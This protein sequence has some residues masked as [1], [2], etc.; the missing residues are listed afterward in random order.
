MAR[1][2]PIPIDEHLLR[3]WP[4]PAA[5][6]DKSERGTVLVVGGSRQTPGAVLLAAEAALRVGAGKVQIATAADTAPALAV[7]LPEAFVE[8]LPVLRGG[9]L[10]VAGSDRILELAEDVDVVLL[11][12]GLS[13]P[14]CASL[15]LAQVVPRLETA[16][17]ID[18]L[19]TAYLTDHLDG[20]RHLDGRVLLTPNVAELAATLHQKED[21]VDNDPLGATR[22]LASA[23]GAV[24]LGGAD[25]SYVA[26]PQDDVWWQGSGSLGLAT[27]GSG[28]VKA[29]AVVGLV[30][31]GATPQQAAA[32]GS[33]AHGQAGER[34]AADEPGFLA[35]DLL[36]AIPLELSRLEDADG[37]AR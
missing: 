6:G 35:R 3:S 21:E 26:T 13:S 27:A 28:D 31:R 10:A 34:L 30:A 23:T 22:K 5:S 8:G 17:V 11:G 18:A 19:G 2:T 36:R 4:L 16:V 32:W 25:D 1:E 20:V 14:E 24:V 7:A 33:W 9:E 15:L 29:G 12:P 37:G